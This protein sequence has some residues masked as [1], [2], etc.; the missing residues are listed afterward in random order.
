MCCLRRFGCPLT[1][2]SFDVFALPGGNEAG[3]VGD[4][5]VMTRVCIDVD[6]DS[7]LP[8]YR[9]LID[10]PDVRRD[11]TVSLAGGQRENMGAL[12]VINV[13]LSNTIAFSGLVVAIASWRGVRRDPPQVQIERDGVRVTVND[14]SAETL[15]RVIE[16]FSSERP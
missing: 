5:E 11:A 2:P 10:D 7:R 12:D 1:A 8:L 15:R 3:V 16:A 6:E 13:V 4:I 9:W 14:A